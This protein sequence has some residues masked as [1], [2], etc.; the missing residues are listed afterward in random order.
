MKNVDFKVIIGICL[1]LAFSGRLQAQLPLLGDLLSGSDAPGLEALP[2]DLLPGNDGFLPGLFT[3]AG[4]FSAPLEAL[5]LDMIVG[6]ASPLLGLGVTTLPVGGLA[7]TGL[8]LLSPLT[9]NA[10]EAPLAIDALVGG[11]LGLQ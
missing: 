5:P 7:S 8:P 6:A 3:A 2:L 11:V 4:A 1:T 10:L 9:I